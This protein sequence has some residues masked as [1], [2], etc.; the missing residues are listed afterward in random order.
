MPDS[1]GPSL[2]NFFTTNSTFCV[3][4]Y[5]LVCFFFKGLST[6]VRK[7]GTVL[8]IISICKSKLNHS[9]DVPLFYLSPFVYCWIEL[10]KIRLVRM[11]HSIRTV[12]ILLV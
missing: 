12:H 8:L 11:D 3:E 7:N 10:V 5:L 9:S 4:V 2:I 1:L 6:V